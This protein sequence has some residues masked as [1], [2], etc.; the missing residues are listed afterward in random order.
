VGSLVQVVNTSQL[1]LKLD[2]PASDIHPHCII[3]YTHMERIL[4]GVVVARA[5]DDNSV[6]E[7]LLEEVFYIPFPLCKFKMPN[8]S[9]G[10]SSKDLFGFSIDDWKTAFSF[11]PGLKTQLS[12]FTAANFPCGKLD[13]PEN[14]DE[15]YGV[16]GPILA[17][18]SATEQ[19]ELFSKDLAK[20]ARYQRPRDGRDQSK[21]ELFGFRKEILCDDLVEL[22]PEALRTALQGACTG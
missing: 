22:L 19:S 15:K 8:S 11:G 3:Q 5:W 16:L 4:A 13:H 14:N 20:N 7:D 18:Y 6:I 2:V 10:D 12:E 21:F 1:E 9:P 17:I